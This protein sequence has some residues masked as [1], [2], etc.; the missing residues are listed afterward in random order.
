[1]TTN[2]IITTDLQSLEVEGSLIELFELELNDSITIYFH[3]GFNSTLGEIS[4]DGNTYIPLPAMMEGIEI[5]SDGASNRPT[6]HVANVTNLFKSALNGQ[7]F[8]F[9][10]LISKRITRRQTLDTY[11][12]NANYE[13]PK[14]VYII[15]RIAQENSTVVTFELTAPYD[16]SGIKIPNR[17]VVGKYCSWIYQGIDNPVASGGCSW[18]STN[19]VDRNGIQYFIY[20]DIEDRPLLQASSVTI[21]SYSA[22]HNINDFVLYNGNYWRSEVSDNS[23]TPSGNSLLWKQVFF[24]SDWESGTP[25]SVGTLTRHSDKIWKCLLSTSSIEPLNNSLYWKRVDF[26]GKTLNSCKCRFQFTP[27]TEGATSA[28]KDTSIPLPFG[29]FPGSVK[30]N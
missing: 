9:E 4:Y 16:V 14:R 23:D 7:G 20:F 8:T 19:S 10:D 18:R 17:V 22:P 13:L 5:S 3:P 6:L 27:T 25:Y 12:S 21:L 29:A 30:F 11:L 26:C 15:D 28:T 24:W 1:M 2:N